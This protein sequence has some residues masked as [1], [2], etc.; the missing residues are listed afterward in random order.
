[1]VA[2][3]TQTKKLTPEEYLTIEVTL[4]DRHEYRNEEMTIMPGGKP[5]HNDIGGNFTSRLKQH[6]VNNLIEPS[7]RI[8]GFGFRRFKSIPI[9]M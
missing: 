3:L 1:M 8:S 4:P 2:Q 9:P 7:M 6:F 5:N